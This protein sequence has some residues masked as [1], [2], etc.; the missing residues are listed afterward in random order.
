MAITAQR[1]AEIA[2][3]N[4]AMSRGPI[5][6][7]GKAR[8]SQNGIRHGLTARNPCLATDD[9]EEYGRLRKTHIDHFRPVTTYEFDIVDQLA[10]IAW[11]I[12]R[13]ESIEIALLDQEIDIRKPDIEKAFQ[14]I[15][16][17]GLW[18]IGFK[19]LADHC[20][21]TNTLDRHQARLERQYRRTVALYE[22]I[23]TTDEPTP[24]AAAQEQAA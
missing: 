5:T 21:A 13:A 2:R 8:S 15:D 14:T 24:A 1:K 19:S 9:P 23:K 16:R 11:R 20:N 18:A 4:G 12:R 7:E 3:I 22:K 17:P 10:A 6:P